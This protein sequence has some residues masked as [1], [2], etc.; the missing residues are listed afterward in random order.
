L[1]ELLNRYEADLAENPEKLP[2]IAET[3]FESRA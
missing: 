1:T 2:K 3:D